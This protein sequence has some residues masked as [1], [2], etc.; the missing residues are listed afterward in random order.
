MLTD[1][2]PFKPLA[3]PS[4]DPGKFSYFFDTS[5]KRICLLAPERFYST[6]V[7]SD[8]GS[9]DVA[10]R[11]AATSRTARGIDT[12]HGAS[13]RSQSLRKSPQMMA[14]SPQR[15]LTTIGGSPPHI[16]SPQDVS[17]L[18]NDANVASAMT[19]QRQVPSE[20]Y[21]INGINITVSAANNNNTLE[22]QYAIIQN[23]EEQMLQ[24][25]ALAA[26]EAP[27]TD[28]SITSSQL[29][30]TTSASLTAKSWVLE[31]QDI[32]SA[33]CVLA[34]LF[35]DGEPLFDL[36]Q[37]LQYRKQGIISD[38]N[39]GAEI[40]L[41]NDHIASCLKRIDDVQARQMIIDMIQLNPTNR[42]RTVKDLIDKY[43]PSVFPPFFHLL[44][45]GIMSGM[46]LKDCGERIKILQQIYD[47][48]IEILKT[49][50]DD[51]YNCDNFF[52]EMMHK[53]F[54]HS[55]TA[56]ISYGSEYSTS[57]SLSPSL[58]PSMHSVKDESDSP[59]QDLVK[60]VQQSRQRQNSVVRRL[61]HL[62][63]QNVSTHAA[64]RTA[65]S[66]ENTQISPVA[67]DRI[68]KAMEIISGL[69]CS[70]TRN[71]QS[72]EMRVKGLMLIEKISEHSTDYNRLQRLVPY[73]CVMLGDVSP[74]VKVSAIK[75][76]TT[77]LTRVQKFPP[78]EINLFNDYLLPA[79]RSLISHSSF[80]DSM[81]PL[82]GTKGPGISSI[83]N[84]TDLTNHNTEMVR[85]TV[86][87]YLPLLAYQAKRFLELA[88]LMK[89]HHQAQQ[90]KLAKGSSENL[91]GLRGTSVTDEDPEDEDEM[92]LNE[93]THGGAADSNMPENT[94]FETVS[95]STTAI[96]S[97]DKDLSVL[98]DEF[99]SLI[100]A[101]SM[102]ECSSVKRS[103]LVNII[104]LCAF[105]GRRKSNDFVLPIMITFLNDQDWRLRQSFFEQV[106]AVSVFVGPFSLK[107]FILPCIIQGMYDRE[108]HVIEQAVNGL[109]SLCELG[110]FDHA[111]MVSQLAP[112]IA[113]LLHHPN[114]W[115][116]YDA[117]AFF[118]AMSRKIG[119]SDTGCYLIDL[120][121]PYFEYKIYDMAITE[122][123]LL[124]AQRE[125]LTRH[126]YDTVLQYCCNNI[127]QIGE[128]QRKMAQE[129]SSV[130]PTSYWEEKLGISKISRADVEKL[131][132]MLPYIE[133]SARVLKSKMWDVNDLSSTTNLGLS[134]DV[135]RLS[136]E[137][138]EQTDHE[139]RIP[140][141]P[142]NTVYIPVDQVYGTDYNA[143][144]P[145]F[146]SLRLDAA[147]D[148]ATVD[149]G[150][151][152]LGTT[153]PKTTRSMSQK[154]G[155]AA[156]E[157]ATSSTNNGLESSSFPKVGQLSARDI[158]QFRP[159][160][161]FFAES[162]EHSSA[163]N[164]IAVHSSRQ[165]FIT[166]SN[167]STV[168]LWDL[169]QFDNG[170]NPMVSKSTYH[171][172]PSFEA[173]DTS[174]GSASTINEHVLSVD[175]QHN[176]IA[177][178]TNRGNIHII[179]AESGAVVNRVLVTEDGR[180]VFNVD[181]SGASSSV[182]SSAINVVRAFDH[183]ATPILV[184]GNRHGHLVAVDSRMG[185]RRGREAFCMRNDAQGGNGL[186]FARHSYHM[187]PITAMCGSDDGTWIVTGTRRGF[188]TL[189]DLRFQI[190]VMTWR[191]SPLESLS[192]GT[193]TSSSINYLDAM[194]NT[195]GS[196]SGPSIYIAT[197]SR[198][199]VVWDMEKQCV[200][201]RYILCDPDS[202]MTSTSSSRSQQQQ[203]HLVR[204]ENENPFAVGEL[205][206]M[207]S[208]LE[209]QQRLERGIARQTP[210]SASNTMM[211]MSMNLENIL[212]HS[213]FEVKG[214]CV[215]DD[216]NVIA[217]ASDRCIRFLDRK[218]PE[219]NSYIISGLDSHSESVFYRRQQ[220]HED[221]EDMPMSN[222]DIIREQI[223]EDSDKKN[224]MRPRGGVFS[225][226][227]N[228][229]HR[230]TVTDVKIAGV[231]FPLL[232]SAARD[233]TVRLML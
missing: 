175:I 52:D 4:D 226:P 21:N 111:T 12:E 173:G 191:I 146:E 225:M 16:G 205:E 232:A 8:G 210:G 102:D 197:S 55:A 40:P 136:G 144:L 53:L 18:S 223:V 15:H 217:G 98:Q 27:A 61:S 145:K 91:K 124:E 100:L 154:R 151:D 192:T 96:S 123:N 159:K 58:S 2:A 99:S 97:Y 24:Q 181:S 37:L 34:Q 177:A 62:I 51:H 115:I 68:Q 56:D 70:S 203:K 69:V 161:Q 170:I 228:T 87:E 72:A 163:V 31:N 148:N 82:S 207:K 105:Y 47:P 30:D 134:G 135:I 186:G 185:H 110:M 230:D 7:G 214:L 129:Q 158:C 125:P 162:R 196:N 35:L 220:K 166:G 119:P 218:N 198:D 114:T 222:E 143:S 84:Q 73:T 199:V 6:T 38:G 80:G 168:K 77:I 176:V 221:P 42:I 39:T 139:R 224:S 128:Y 147:E 109:I 83:I 204:N 89:H 108:E 20:V 23:L 22:Q 193:G 95:G 150:H 216:G 121:Q 189:W 46:V 195:Y 11:R 127:D 153:P 179:N 212:S 64:D 131:V 142:L 17:A 29:L 202:K 184:C 190:P 43:T 75:T 104:Q 116:R 155:P 48:L 45:E 174:T 36:S 41:H 101:L 71:A 188:L 79:I 211:A 208:G 164:E 92:M 90:Q 44:H 227:L 33:G 180:A 106:V 49:Y 60:R 50:D 66:S 28:Q 74:L 149:A 112:R 171:I 169:R 213:N 81:K 229:V 107:D 65:P 57:P 25:R 200:S 32:F 86:A 78:S 140:K 130:D 88:Q 183:G 122:Y 209:N 13:G 67:R 172:S 141:V 54:G 233:G 165:W 178:S 160:G 1:L 206:Q 14:A 201:K 85:A 10:V 157:G 194:Q 63:D 3:L 94:V 113:P 5:E 19:S 117:I 103:L 137:N 231:Q 138:D 9:N 93:Q 126:I 120:L 118:S 219:E 215:N 133:Q 76:L 187:G 167:D 182:L 156:Q 152:A 26:H 132:L 59:T